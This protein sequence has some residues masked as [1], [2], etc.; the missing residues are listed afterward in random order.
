M[1]NKIL[2][3]VDNESCQ[4]VIVIERGEIKTDSIPDVKD[5]LI[6]KFIENGHYTAAHFKGDNV[7]L[8]SMNP[9]DIL[10]QMLEVFGNTFDT[11]FNAKFQQAIYSASHLLEVKH[12][13]KSTAFLKMVEAQKLVY[14]ED[15]PEDKK[16]K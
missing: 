12:G 10:A 4:P 5:S 13:F 9:L 3:H 6:E 11:E 8:K 15:I 16:E 2:I 7:I 14:G 1:V